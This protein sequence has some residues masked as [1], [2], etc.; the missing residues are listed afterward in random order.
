MFEKASRLKLRFH[1]KG[2]CTVEDLWDLAVEELDHIYQ[3]VKAGL[4]TTENSLLQKRKTREESLAELQAEILEHIVTIKLA[5]AEARVN[6]AERLEKK[7]R[8]TELLAQKQD[9]ALLDKSPDEIAKM[10]DEL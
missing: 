8:L 7:R 2:I 4:R 1:F 6:R 5:E 9:E 3:T 10:I